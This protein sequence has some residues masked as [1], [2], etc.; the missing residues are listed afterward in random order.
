MKD[1][2][3]YTQSRFY[4]RAQGLGRHKRSTRWIAICITCAGIIALL[5]HAMMVA[6]GESEA[7]QLGWYFSVSEI[8]FGLLVMLASYMLPKMAAA[9][10]RRHLRQY[11]ALVREAAEPAGSKLYILDDIERL[12]AH[13]ILVTFYP[14][15][16]GPLHDDSAHV[17]VS[18]TR[19]G[20]GW[21][22][23]KAEHVPLIAF[24][25][26]HYT[27]DD[28]GAIILDYGDRVIIRTAAN[29]FDI[30]HWT[31]LITTALA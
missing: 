13:N 16:S 15:K 26:A 20:A 14:V 30:Q 2:P 21:L 3:T 9:H 12:D 7:S 22:P 10:E 8:A 6:S 1:L 29:Q 28:H 27:V 17:I 4:S 5:I 25:L 24:P 19:S 31:Q 11:R 23:C 18:V